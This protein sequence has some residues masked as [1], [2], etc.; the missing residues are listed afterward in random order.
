M[1]KANKN[2]LDDLAKALLE[3]ETLEEAEVDEI[4]KDAVLPKEAK[5][6]S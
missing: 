1:L 4:L 3:Q 6:H 2:F 5:L